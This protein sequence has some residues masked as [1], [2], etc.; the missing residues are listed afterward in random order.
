MKIYKWS[1]Q[2][3]QEYGLG[4]IL[5]LGENVDDARRNAMI[6]FDVDYPINVYG[7]DP[8]FRK[9]ILNDLARHPRDGGLG[10]FIFGSA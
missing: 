9:D 5:A 4:H 2:A 8:D 10:F 6:Q 7:H 3:L 1:S